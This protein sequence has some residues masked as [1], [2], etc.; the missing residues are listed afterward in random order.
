MSRGGQVP[1]RFCP[2][3]K[4]QRALVGDVWA[5]HRRHGSATLCPMSE[6]DPRT[7][8]A[9]LERRAYSLLLP[10]R[11]PKPKRRPLPLARSSK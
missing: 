6:R 8:I 9:P 10:G 4:K 1:K 5:P 7:A 11:N 2:V 3:C